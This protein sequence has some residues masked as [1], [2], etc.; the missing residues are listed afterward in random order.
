[1]SNARVDGN[2]PH[3][4]L[5]GKIGTCFDS[6]L[7]IQCSWFYGRTLNRG[8]VTRPELVVLPFPTKRQI[9][10]G[11]EVVGKIGFSV[12]ADDARD[13]VV[14]GSGGKLVE[15]IVVV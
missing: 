8:D 14:L 4:M 3:D 10:F 1:M 15:R 11:S 13:P 7:V 5:N 9:S 2:G 6:I 12:T